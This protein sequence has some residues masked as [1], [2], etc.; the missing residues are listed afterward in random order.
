MWVA[1]APARHGKPL[2]PRPGDLVPR[3]FRHRGR[4]SPAPGYHDRARHSDRADVL[5]AGLPGAR[6]SNLPPVSPRSRRERGTTSTHT[7][8]CSGHGLRLRTR[9][10]GHGRPAGGV[11]WSAAGRARARPTG[12]LERSRRLDRAPAAA[13]GGLGY[14]PLQLHYARRGVASTPSAQEQAAIHPPAGTFSW[15]YPQH[16]GCAAKLWPPGASGV[17][18]RG[19]VMAFENDQGL[20][21]DGVAGPD[22]WKALIAAVSPASVE[23][24]LH[25]R[26]GQRD[27]AD[28]GAVAQR[29]TVDRG[30]RSTPASPRRRRRP[31]PTR[32]TSTSVGDDERH[33]PRRQPLQRPGIPWI[34]YFNGGDA[35][36]GFVRALL[37]LPAEPWLCRDAVLRGRAQVYPYTPIGTIVNVSIGRTATCASERHR[38]AHA[39]RE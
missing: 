28:A 1:G 13:A 27:L 36:H 37:R 4:G 18:T 2:A 25:V 33:Q 30:R 15:R 23:L 38:A 17:M 35:L 6:Q 26:D 29:H 24:R 32:S 14:L 10:K 3:W 8:S 31:A 22:V 9:G 19:A 16:A 11:A 21:A 12:E 7:R 39:T 34:S 20:P 5:E